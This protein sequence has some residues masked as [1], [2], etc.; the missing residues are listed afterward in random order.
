[1]RNSSSGTRLAVPRTKTE[2]YRVWYI[3]EDATV[4]VDGTVV[5]LPTFGTSTINGIRDFALEGKMN[6]FYH[7]ILRD[8]HGKHTDLELQATYQYF[9]DR[10]LW[11]TD[12]I[13]DKATFILMEQEIAERKEVRKSLERLEFEI[14]ACTLAQTHEELDKQITNVLRVPSHML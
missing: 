8:W 1:M 3:P 11:D 2:G 5:P 14:G 12:D 9:Y 7:S 13:F 6:S 4:E 10:W